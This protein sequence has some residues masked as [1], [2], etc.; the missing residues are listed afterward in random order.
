M[1]NILEGY[2]TVLLLLIL[3]RDNVKETLSSAVHSRFYYR[4]LISIVMSAYLF[5]NRPITVL[6]DTKHYPWFK[7]KDVAKVLGFPNCKKALF[8]HVSKKYKSTQLE[9][10][11]TFDRSQPECSRVVF[12]SEPGL[13]ELLFASKLPKA[14]KFRYWVFE[15]VL[16]S[17]RKYGE[18]KVSSENSEILNSLNKALATNETTDNNLARINQEISSMV[19]TPTPKVNSSCFDLKLVFCVLIKESI[20]EINGVCEYKCLCTENRNLN[21]ALKNAKKEGFELCFLRKD[22]PNDVNIMDRAKEIM[23]HNGIPYDSVHNSILTSH[24]FV[25]IVQYV[26]ENV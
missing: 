18:Y 20:L 14:S 8:K 3:Y 4:V 6:Y 5:D 12:I 25:N 22:V 7:G 15:K 9:I 17:L 16:P 13:Y 24:D 23:N 10:A 1:A 21:K 2:K 19:I 26:I 11:G